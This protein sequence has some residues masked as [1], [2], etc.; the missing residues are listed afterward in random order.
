MTLEI[1]VLTVLEVLQDV[2]EKMVSQDSLDDEEQK[3]DNLS[4][5][6][7]SKRLFLYFLNVVLEWLCFWPQTEYFSCTTILG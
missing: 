7:V 6:K 1:S 5:I 3:Y 4:N 2:M